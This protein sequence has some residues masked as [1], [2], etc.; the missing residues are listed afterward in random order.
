MSETVSHPMDGMT[1]GSSLEA[2]PFEL[3]HFEVI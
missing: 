1:G 2:L 3:E